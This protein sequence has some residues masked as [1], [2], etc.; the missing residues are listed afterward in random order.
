[1]KIIVQVFFFANP[2]LHAYMSQASFENC[3][4]RSEIYNCTLKNTN[5]VSIIVVVVFVIVVFSVR[6]NRVALTST[7][8]ICHAVLVGTR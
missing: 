4:I 2:V 5:K 1:M 6:V 3:L 8:I 7:T